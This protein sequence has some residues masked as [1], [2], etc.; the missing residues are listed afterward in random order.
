M[1]NINDFKIFIDTIANKSGRGTITP[2]QFNSI[3]KQ[4]VMAWYN[5]RMEKIDSNGVPM[6][7]SGYN[8]KYIEDFMEI[9]ETVELLSTLGEVLIP[10]GTTYDLQGNLAPEFWA[11][12]SLGFRY[13][14][15]HNG[16]KIV[17]ERP[18]EIA[19]ENEWYKKTSSLISPPTM[20]YPIAKFTKDKIILRPKSLTGVIL[21]Y[22]RYPNTPKWSY[23]I[24]NSR[25]LYDSAS[26]TDIEAPKEA[27]NQIAMIALGFIGIHLR[28]QDL[29]QMSNINEQKGL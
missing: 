9:K 18:I 28:E 7:M 14:R 16:N 13:F 27:F 21:T 11:F 4:S 26:S 24:V 23:S 6:V 5:T 25:P 15:T 10:D 19:K 17:E 29:F 3:V 20:K 1:I 12:E 22:V 8:Q 2:S